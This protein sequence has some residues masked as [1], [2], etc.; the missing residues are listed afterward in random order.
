MPDIST[1][2]V[3]ISLL[4]FVLFV[5]GIYHI[6]RKLGQ[7]EVKVDTMWDFTMRRTMSEVVKSGLGS[8]NSPFKFNEEVQHALKSMKPELIAFWATLPADITDSA[9]LLRIEAQFGEQ[10]LRLVG[11]PYK[12]TH[13]ACLLLALTVAKQSNVIELAPGVP[14]EL[15]MVKVSVPTP[16]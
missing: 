15:E 6:G 1:A 12:L 5:I 7:I 4:N 16:T 14:I 11:L 10:I 13:D 2:V 8:V 9:A 3:G